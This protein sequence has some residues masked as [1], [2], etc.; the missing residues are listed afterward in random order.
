MDDKDSIVYALQRKL[1]DFND[2]FSKLEKEKE[3][4]KKT[5]ESKVTILEEQLVDRADDLKKQYES[6]YNETVNKY[7]MQLSRQRFESERT[8][9]DTKKTHEKNID[10]INGQYKKSVADL[11]LQVERLYKKNTE[12]YNTMKVTLEKKVSETH[13]ENKR[14]NDYI[15]QLK[16][17]FRKQQDTFTL[18]NSQF[19]TNMNKQKELSDT[20]I[21]ARNQVIEHLELQLRKLGEE[22]VER[23]NLLENK[24]KTLQLE[25]KESNEKYTEAKILYE[26]ASFEAN[27]FRP[28]IEKLRDTIDSISEKLKTSMENS[29]LYQKNVKELNYKI[30]EKDAVLTRQGAEL[31]ILL[32]SVHGLERENQESKSLYKISET[33]LVDV[34]SDNVKMGADLHHKKE[35]IRELLE[36]RTMLEGKIKYVESER[37][38]ALRQVTS[39]EE[40]LNQLQIEFAGASTMITT[41][42]EMLNQR[43]EEMKKY[44][45]KMKDKLMASENNE[46]MYKMYKEETEKLKSEINRLKAD[47]VVKLNNMTKEMDEKDKQVDYFRE[48]S[49][50]IVTKERETLELI[51]KLNE[52]KVV[53]SKFEAMYKAEVETLTNKV[54][55][56]ERYLYDL[57]NDNE[58]LKTELEEYMREVHTNRTKE[59]EPE[60]EEN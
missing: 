19:I 29:E 33:T 41:K 34:K 52:S 8:L 53:I 13:E 48:Q 1:M 5:L 18:T 39:V 9:E 51:K 46:K 14:L 45:E 23:I 27:F 25:L 12:D 3:E 36:E 40:K 15:K 6:Q 56:Q 37:D 35:R 16:E 30:Q 2:K 58:T 44:E 26:K 55:E 4:Y 42:T 10:T 24:T 7:D 17:N 11:E 20:E 54:K 47:F 49:K 43:Y 32:D 57:R 21:H 50:G 22:S 60:E 38:S 28:E 31:A 59:E